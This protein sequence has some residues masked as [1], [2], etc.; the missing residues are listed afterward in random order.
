MLHERATLLHRKKKKSFTSCER[1]KN[2]HFGLSNVKKSEGRTKLTE[3]KPKQQF[4]KKCVFGKIR[5]HKA[6]SQFHKN[7]YLPPPHEI[8]NIPIPFSEPN[9]ARLN[10]RLYN[11]V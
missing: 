6:V 9:L 1:I 2:W 3:K 8:V 11:T 4:T 10:S 7:S 5:L